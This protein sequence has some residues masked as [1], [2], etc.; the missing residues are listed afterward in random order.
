MSTSGRY[1][2]FQ[3]KRALAM[4]DYSWAQ[5]HDSSGPFHDWNQTLDELVE[6][7]YDAIR[8]DCFPQHIAKLSDETLPDPTRYSLNN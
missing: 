6:R 8:I 2:Q 1:S 5:L 4:W 3:V 7:G